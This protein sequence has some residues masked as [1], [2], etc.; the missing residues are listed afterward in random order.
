MLQEQS[1]SFATLRVPLNESILHMHISTSTTNIGIDQPISSH[2]PGS[3]VK[4]KCTSNC[5]SLKSKP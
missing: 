2:R 3:Y 4:V 5:Q 1:F